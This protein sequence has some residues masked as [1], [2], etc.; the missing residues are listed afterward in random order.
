[1][2]NKTR[3]AVAMSGGVDSATTAALLQEMGYD[4]IGVSMQLWCEKR[5]SLSS[6]RPTCCS[7]EDIDDAR[8]VCHLLGIPF[9][10]LNLEA[11]F[12]SY[13][14]DYFCREYVYGRTPNP[15]IACNRQIK[16]DFLLQK[17]LSLEVEY[18]ATGHYAR[19]ESSGDE[20]RLLK[21]IDPLSDQS[22]FLYPLGQW[23]LRHLLF[24]MGNYLKTEVRHMAAERGLPVADKPK[25]QDL[26]FVSNGDYRDFLKGY[27][28]P[29][30]GDIVDMEGR[31]LGRHQGIA[32]YTIGQ[33][34]GLGLA[35]D[36]RLYVVA[37]DATSNMLV[38]GTED[39]L[40]SSRVL[41]TKVSFVC[42]KPQ[43]PVTVKAKVRY[44]S[45]EGDAVLYPR[46]DGV[47][48]RFH[49]P[50]RAIAPGQAVVFYQGDQI[51]GGG[52]IQAS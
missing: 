6:S 10:T 7:I 9:Y 30:P 26:C 24:P 1:M 43:K 16:F 51:L 2:T 11:Q 47:E 48:I 14:V 22:Y 46:E 29:T 3:V 25:S 13:V 18:L 38:V 23:E 44:R 39:K 42:K 32:F 40:F 28:S 52:I 36:K 27:I 20:Y 31:V 50:Q 5:H 4:V 8:R 49:R 33:R 37:I 17:V 35:S 15:C 34:G 21:G 19:I 12:Q 45:P 41:A